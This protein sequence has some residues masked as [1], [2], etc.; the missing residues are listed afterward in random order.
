MTD[1]YATLANKTTMD[2]PNANKVVIMNLAEMRNMEKT[3]ESNAFQLL[4]DVADVRK[5]FEARWRKTGEK[6]NIFNVAGITRKEV[7]MC[8]VLADLLDPKGKHCQGSRYLSLFWETVSPKLPGQPELSINDTKVTPEFIIDENRRIDITFEDGRIF[9]PIEVKIG[10]GDQPKQVADYYEFARKKNK[11]IHVPLLYLTV[12]GH[13]P[14]DFSKAGIGKDAYVR[15]SFR[16]DILAWLE[17]CARWNTPET[18]VPVR[19][20]LRQLIAAI[21]SL[22]GKSEDA[23]ME[24]AIFKLVTKDDDSA[25]AALAICGAA[26]FDNR[27]LETFKGPVLELVKKAFPDFE[28]FV[29]S[30]WYYL[31]VPIKDDRY[32]FQINYLWDKACV[33][34]N[35]ANAGDLASAEGKAL[36]EKMSALFGVRPSPSSGFAWYIEGITWSGFARDDLYQFH[37]CK[38]YTD[39]PQEAADKIIGIVRELENVKA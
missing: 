28:Y 32:W 10:A 14:S 13:E 19:E 20:N 3:Q 33:A 36:Y 5:S 6:Y 7:Y 27:V 8:R 31:N 1:L 21:K 23:E 34:V 26:D 39:H 24:D 2:R 37:L 22:C 30:G 18:T 17:V 15:L 38:L 29:E 12:D 25:R 11:D 4:N 16:D 9:V 35:T